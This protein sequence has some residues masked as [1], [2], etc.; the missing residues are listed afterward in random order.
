M[1]GDAHASGRVLASLACPGCKHE[2]ATQV[3]V[4]VETSRRAI[5]RP[6]TAEIIHLCP[7]C[8]TLLILSLHPAPQEAIAS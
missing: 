7:Q 4:T 2:H 1:S 3:R 8:G 6:V 5:R